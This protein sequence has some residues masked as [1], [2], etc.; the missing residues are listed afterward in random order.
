[1]RRTYRGG[2]KS[3]KKTG[4][5][6]HPSPKSDKEYEGISAVVF[7]QPVEDELMSASIDVLGSDSKGVLRVP[8]H[9]DYDNNNEPQFWTCNS[10]YVGRTAGGR[11]GKFQV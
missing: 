5:W 6:S 11:L 3:Q 2:H 9:L 1:M 8:V 4:S 10:P 7:S